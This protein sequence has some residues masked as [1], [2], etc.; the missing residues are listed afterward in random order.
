[1]KLFLTSAGLQKETRDYFLELLGRDLKIIKVVFIP[2]AADPEKDK[3]FVDSAKDELK[4]IGLGFS[5]IDLKDEN[6]SSLERKLL[7][8]DV[9]YVNGGNAF[10]LL[11]W[12][13]KSGFDRVVK[14]FLDRGGIYIGVSAGSV[15]A[16]TEIDCAGWNE[17]WDK[18]IVGIKDT[19]GLG[20]VDFAISPHYTD[21]DFKLLFEKS[22]SVSYPVIG[23]ADSQAILV[24]GKKIR[25]V[26]RG[27]PVCFNGKKLGDTLI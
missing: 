11:D 13:R 2:T 5:E 8:A 7:G 22:K 4:D 24:D 12:V 23:L 21:G 14:N 10:Y 20:L 26:G 27:E 17:D 6:K 3:G 16:G 1:M 9:I 25:A 15:L 19:R 18:N